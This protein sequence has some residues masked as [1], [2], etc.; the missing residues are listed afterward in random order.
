MKPNKPIWPIK[1]SKTIYTH[2]PTHWSKKKKK[3]K[4]NEK[5]E[6]K[7][8]GQEYRG[9][10]WW[11]SFSWLDLDSGQGSFSWPELDCEGASLFLLIWGM[12]EREVG[13]S[14]SEREERGEIFRS[15][16]VKAKKWREEKRKRRGER[17]YVGSV[18]PSTI[19]GSHYYCK[20]LS[21]IEQEMKPNMIYFEWVKK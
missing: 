5:K 11:G 14:V 20:I 16:R 18:W 1:P 6:R 4:K 3:K 7:L 10:R 2:T 17:T 15:G 9:D 12:W 21:Y 19:N 13:D 8:K